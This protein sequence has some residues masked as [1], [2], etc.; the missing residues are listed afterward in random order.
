MGQLTRR[1]VKTAFADFDRWRLQET[2]LVHLTS[3]DVLD[4]DR[5]LRRLDLTLRTPD[6]LNIAI[7]RR[8]GAILATL[9]RKM[10]ASAQSLGLQVAAI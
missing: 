8:L 2:E 9:D 5:Y 10:A 1:E 6:A 4:A 7:A 3:A